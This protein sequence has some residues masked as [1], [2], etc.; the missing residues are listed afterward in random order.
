VLV[1]VDYI[2]G[3]AAP[4]S[5]RLVGMFRFT[6]LPLEH[7]REF[8]G[9]DHMETVI[10]ERYATFHEGRLLGYPLERI[11]AALLRELLD[12]Y[13]VSTVIACS[14]DARTTFDRFG[15]V[16]I[17]IREIADCRGYRVREAVTSRLLEGR[18]RVR[19]RLDRLEVRDAEGGRLV[20]KYHWIPSL[21]TEPPLPIEEARQPGAPV[22]FIAVRP[23]GVRDFDIVVRPIGLGALLRRRHAR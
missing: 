9:T 5:S 12:R 23:G 7:A 1:E 10:A 16:V 8:L 2:V 14:A 11:D 3:P 15:E 22:G 20:L 13:A 6:L 19:T 21:A 18:G 17:P 4:G